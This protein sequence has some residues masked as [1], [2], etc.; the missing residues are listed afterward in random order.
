MSWRGRPVIQSTVWLN[1]GAVDANSPTSSA[2]HARVRPSW[3]LVVL[4]TL[5]ISLPIGMGEP[6]SLSER[7]E[8]P[9]IS[10]AVDAFSLI[11][12]DE[13]PGEAGRRASYAVFS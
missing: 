2:K 12:P 10:G 1:T 4:P 11:P 5:I 8:L 9:G 7:R 6:I 13:V 3:T